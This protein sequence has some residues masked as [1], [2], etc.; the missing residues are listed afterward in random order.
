MKI[1]LPAAAA[2]LALSCVFET[3][4]QDPIVLFMGNSIAR[5]KPVPA[6][7]WHGDWGMAATARDKD[8]VHRTVALLAERGVA[9][10]GVLADRDCPECDGAIDE[11]IHNMDQIERLKPRWVVIQLAEHSGVIELLSGKMT[12]QYRRLLQGLT[13]LKVPHIYCLGSWGE[14]EAD[15]L[16]AQSI[17]YAIR[18]FPGVE[19]LPLHAASSDTANYGDTTL[20]KDAGVVWHPGD[21]GMEAMAR[22]LADAISAD[23]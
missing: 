4:K 5:N 19:F 22:I 13:A 15:G 8:Y 11:Q 7:G 10:E 16:H 20:F 14:K 21:R 1:L 9:A 2:L 18:D 12:S 23:R 3:R 6:I 17:H